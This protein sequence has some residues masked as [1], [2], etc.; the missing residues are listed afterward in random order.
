MHGLLSVDTCISKAIINR[1][2]LICISGRN[3]DRSSS[4]QPHVSIIAAGLKP[5]A[6]ISASRLE[7]NASASAEG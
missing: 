6:S 1:M 7:S 5:H 2:H 4:L 3:T